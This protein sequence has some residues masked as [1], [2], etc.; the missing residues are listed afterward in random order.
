MRARIIVLVTL[1]APILGVSCAHA[2]PEADPATRSEKAELPK[3]EKYF[4]DG[5]KAM[6]TGNYDEAIKLLSKA[7]DADPSKTSYR[8]YLARAY[9][10]AG[11]DKKAEEQLQAI[12]KTVPDHVEAGQLLGEIYTAQKKWKE[13]VELLEPLLKYRHDYTT[14]RLLAE[15]TYNLD[16]HDKARKYFE[17]AIKLNDKS[18]AD[19]YQLGNIYLA[20]N[21][22]ALATESYQRA[23][24][25]GLDSPILRYKLGSAYFNLR[26]YFGQISVVT[27]KAGKTGTISNDWYLIEKVPG[28]E[29]TFRAAPSSSA[30][31]QVAKAIADGIEDRP[32]I[33]F[34]KAN[35]YLNARRYRRAYEMFGQ[36]KETIPDEDKALF[37]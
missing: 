14:Y 8:L 23:L 37:Y 31:Y 27:V 1:A 18:A 16:E 35:I 4:L 28:K 7:V 9:R 36:I 12:L 33:H 29:D 5:R 32:D 17:E 30:I 3:G 6:L 24:A 22:F 13:L 26:N 2:A 34:L 10:Y 11:K 20:G 21:F 19:H 25:L 15:A